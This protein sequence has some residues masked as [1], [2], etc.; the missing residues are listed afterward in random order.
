MGMPW[1]ANVPK[2]LL[3]LPNR[4]WLETTWSPDFN[5][6]SIAAAIAAMPVEKHTVP[7]PS[8]MA[9]TFASKAAVVGLP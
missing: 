1:A 2:R 3:V 5:S 7:A 4:K 9:L 6:D 8:S